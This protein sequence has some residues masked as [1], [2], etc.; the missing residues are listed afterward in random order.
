MRMN[1]TGKSR[2][3]AGTR[4]TLRACGLLMLWLGCVCPTEA[5]DWTGQEFFIRP[6]RPRD[7]SPVITGLALHPDGHC[8]AVAGDDHRV[9]ILN[10]ET[11]DVML[12]LSEHVDWVRSLAFSPSGKL[13]ASAAS[14]GQL[15]LWDPTNGS[16]LHRVARL[17]HAISAIRF[18]HDGQYLAA[19]G[20][21]DAVYVYDVETREP[22]LRLS[23]PCLDMRALAFSADRQLIA[24]GGRNGLVRLWSLV[25]G[26]VLRE[27][28]AHQR[29]IRGLA[30]SPDGSTL[31]SCGED[32]TIRVSR[33][34]GEVD[35]VLTYPNA[36]VMSLTFCGPDQLAT[37]GS[38]NVIRIWDMN[39]RVET[40]R[41]AGHTGSVVALDYSGNM[42][43]S[44]GYDTTVRVWKRSRH[45]AED[46]RAARERMG[47]RTE[48]DTERP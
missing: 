44:A 42:L 31:V 2:V 36:K 40:A 16:K 3:V 35:F 15:V 30:F 25:D 43:V 4:G 33:L 38:D 11:G 17:P 46:P 27:F 41:L 7:R 39:E 22:Q 21:G 20:F 23:S 47:T 45:V 1:R 6:E 12:T 32:G 18:S 13:L 37:G 29:R 48:L 5:A 14:D 34:D 28:A 26:P 9:R 8:V 19:V 24:A 10:L